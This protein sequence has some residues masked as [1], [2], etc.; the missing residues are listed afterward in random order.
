MVKGDDYDCTGKE[1]SILDRTKKIKF[2]VFPTISYDGYSVAVLVTLGCICLFYAI[3]GV[4]LFMC[5]RRCYVPRT[6][7]YVPNT[8]SA[9]SSPGNCMGPDGV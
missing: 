5:N 9:V 7:D 6:M 3:F 1:V 4:S 8:P 2:A